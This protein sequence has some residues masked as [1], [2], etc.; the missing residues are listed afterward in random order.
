METIENIKTNFERFAIEQNRA[1]AEGNGKKANR[2][3]K[4]IQLLHEHAKTLNCV[5]IFASYL[6][7]ENEIIKLWASVFCMEI[8]PQIAHKN[9]VK[10][11]HSSEPIISLSA[12]A[13]LDS[14]KNI[15]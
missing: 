10:L 6:E 15:K 3:H 13:T 2:F 12:K 11:T 7:H 14:L 9:L 5:Y 8:A 4:K 1:L